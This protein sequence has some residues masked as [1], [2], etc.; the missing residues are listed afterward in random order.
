MAPHACATAGGLICS[1]T[2]IW[3]EGL[4]MSWNVALAELRS[5]PSET[6]DL[7]GGASPGDAI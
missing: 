5:C 6:L 1:W 2:C 7:A 4:A 3:Q